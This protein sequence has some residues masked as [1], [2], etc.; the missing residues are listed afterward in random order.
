MAA[1]NAVD[2]D[3]IEEKQGKAQVYPNPSTGDF[4]VA[5]EGIQAISVFSVDGKLL[6]TIEVSGNEY[7]IENL[8]KGVYMLKI[9]M[10][11]GVIVNKIVKL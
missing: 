9:D 7:R 11:N 5:C 8:P 2:Y 4:T 10:E 1:V 3:G 6:K